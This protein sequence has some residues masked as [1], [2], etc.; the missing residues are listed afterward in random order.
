MS[1]TEQS[2]IVTMG[3]PAGIGAEITL[4]AWLRHRSR[5]G[6][7]RRHRRTQ[8]GGRHAYMHSIMMAPHGTANGLLGLGA[9]INVVRRCRPTTSL[10]SIPARPILGGMT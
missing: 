5:P 8:M 9:L 7:Y 1:K 10:L 4:G 3:E 6:R 2:I